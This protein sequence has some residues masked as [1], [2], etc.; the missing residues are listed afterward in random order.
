[1]LLHHSLTEQFRSITPA[2][3]AK[4]LI[5]LAQLDLIVVYGL[6]KV[7]GD[8]VAIFDIVQLLQTIDS[9]GEDLAC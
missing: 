7:I 5:V 6:A 9:D 1:M 8:R 3:C 4:D 2:L